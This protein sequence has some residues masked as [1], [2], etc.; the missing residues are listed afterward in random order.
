ML[1]FRRMEPFLDSA[2]TPWVYHNWF[3]TFELDFGA[4]IHHEF[5]TST[6]PLTINE[7]S[8]SFFKVYPNPTT[9]KLIAEGLLINNG[10]LQIQD[11]LG[12]VIYT[13]NI[14]SGLFKITLSLENYAN[15]IYFLKVTSKDID[16]VKKVV[17]Q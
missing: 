6:L 16:Y 15:G 10:Y 2:A 3:K 5:T 9:E 12:R 1:R 4:Y 14:M 17:K 11:K 7:K 8:K 13:E